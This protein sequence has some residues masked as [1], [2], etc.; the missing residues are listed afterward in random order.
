[1]VDYINSFLSKFIPSVRIQDCPIPDKANLAPGF[2][3]IKV[4]D[5]NCDEMNPKPFP[6]EIDFEMR[7][8]TSCRCGSGTVYSGNH[9][10]LILRKHLPEIFFDIRA[11]PVL[12][13]PEYLATFEAS[14]KRWHLRYGIFSVPTIISLNGIIEAPARPREYYLAKSMGLQ[15]DHDDKFVTGDDPRL[16][17]ILAGIILQ[18]WWYYHDGN[19]FCPDPNCSLYNAHWQEELINSQKDEPYILCPEHGMKILTI[20]GE[21][22]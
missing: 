1:M 14:E 22:R 7:K 8:L 13:T 12:I 3:R 10:A 9:Y 18:A 20:T 19:P 11:K 15:P 17:R 5:P 4:F 6:A 16:P 21:E 2:A